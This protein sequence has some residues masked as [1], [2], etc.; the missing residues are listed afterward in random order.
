MFLC[1]CWAVIRPFL[2][3]SMV[4]DKALIRFVCFL[5]DF[6]AFSTVF[7]PPSLGFSEG[8]LAFGCWDVGSWER[9]FLVY[10]FD[11]WMQC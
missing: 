4:F 2:V 6:L 8:L 9:L 5:T 3:S 7:S 10:S 1:A 11:T